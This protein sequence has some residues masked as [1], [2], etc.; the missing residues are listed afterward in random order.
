MSGLMG[1]ARSAGVTPSRVEP[2]S[3][4]ILD[5]VTV[6]TVS[7]LPRLA[8]VELRD[9]FGNGRLVSGRRLHLHLLP[10]AKVIDGVG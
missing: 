6:V 1:E 8:D 2:C 3:V 10:A 9:L 4:L 7:C 5:V